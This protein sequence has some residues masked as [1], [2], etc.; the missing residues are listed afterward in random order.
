MSRTLFQPHPEPRVSSNPGDCLRKKSHLWEI[1][2][3]CTWAFRFCKPSKKESLWRN[4]QP[5]PSTGRQH[6]SGRLCRR[7]RKGGAVGNRAEPG[8]GRPGFGGG[9]HTSKNYPGVRRLC[10]AP[11]LFWLLVPPV[12][13]AQ[14]Q[15]RTKLDWR[16]ALSLRSQ[17]LSPGRASDRVCLSLSR[18]SVVT[19]EVNATPS[20]QC[21]TLRFMA[22]FA[23][24]M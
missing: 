11:W 2:Q 1:L 14:W 20:D 12:W 6:R 23:L 18:L 22:D 5:R 17:L 3:P 13:R 4:V 15:I 21:Y 24:V 19:R 9:V 8:D 10:F 7:L 16:G